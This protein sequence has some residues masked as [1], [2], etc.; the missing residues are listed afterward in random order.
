MFLYSVL[1]LIL[2]LLAPHLIAHFPEHRDLSRPAC[3]HCGQVSSRVF[4]YWPKSRCAKCGTAF[5]QFRLE[6]YLSFGVIALIGF[7]LRGIDPWIF[8]L[9]PF[10]SLG[11][12]VIA[13]TDFDHHLITDQS[14]IYFSIFSL[15]FGWRAYGIQA[16]IGGAAGILIMGL[17]YLLGR[18]Y[19]SWF[20]PDYAH[21]DALGFNDFLLAFP[22]GLL[23]GFPGILYVLF[24]S[25]LLGLFPALFVLVSR[26]SN[27]SSKAFP[28]SPILLISALSLL[29]GWLLTHS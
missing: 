15:L 28:L 2:G 17:I 5:D 8:W 6:I 1:S 13:V 26:K 12:I 27:H 21:A 4:A 16:L 7:W 9:W 19:V 24:L 22:L 23:T 18:L 3:G 10:L 25:S 11:T 20:R 29:G 14:L